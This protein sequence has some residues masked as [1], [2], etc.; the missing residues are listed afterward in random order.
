[1]SRPISR[2]SRDAY[3]DRGHGVRDGLALGVDDRDFIE[4]DVASDRRWERCDPQIG[5]GAGG[6]KLLGGR[7]PARQVGVA[8]KTPGHRGPSSRWQ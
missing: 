8:D 4:G 1:M 5:W 6:A 7:L 3:R 2:V